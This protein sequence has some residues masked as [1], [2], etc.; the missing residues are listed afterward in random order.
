MPWDIIEREDL[1]E[2]EKKEI[3]VSRREQ[4]EQERKKTGEEWK[5]GDKNAILRMFPI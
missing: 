3:E 4:E 2:K 5:L 1:Q